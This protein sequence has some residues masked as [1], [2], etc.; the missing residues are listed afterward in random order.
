MAGMTVGARY[1]EAPTITRTSGGILDRAQ[2]IDIVGGDLNELMGVMYESDSCWPVRLVTLDVNSCVST[3]AKTFDAF[4]FETGTPFHIYAGVDCSVLAGNFEAK[5]T[6]RLE[7][8]ETRAVEKQ[9]W[10][11]TFRT[12]AVN[13]T[14]AGGAVSP[15]VALGLLEEFAGASYAGVPT[16]HVGKRGAVFLASENLLKLDAAEPVTVGGS[17]VV[18]GSGYTSLIGPGGV[19][20]TATEVWVYMTGHIVL[21]RG[22]ITTIPAIDQYTNSSIVLAE[23]TYVPTVDCFTVAIR[24]SLVGGTGPAPFV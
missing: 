9:L 12:E 13:I 19:V 17:I 18:P 22:P 23:R 6:T 14:P 1:V 24:M 20:A 5:A 3:A 10:E 11:N 2:V 4:G 21:R 16:L 8:G 7:L 15:K